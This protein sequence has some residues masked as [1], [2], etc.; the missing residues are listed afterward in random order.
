MVAGAAS[1]DGAAGCMSA[2]TPAWLAAGQRVS[3]REAGRAVRLAA[4]LEGRYG[5][6][7]EVLATGA[8]N[9]KQAPG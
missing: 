1:R 4:A 6:V 5:R 3:W 2:S 7:R 9:A 8:V